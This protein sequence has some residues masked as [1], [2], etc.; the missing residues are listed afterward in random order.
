MTL[1]IPLSPN[2]TWNDNELRYALRSWE[3]YS[4]PSEVVIIG[5]K[6]PDWLTGV[7]WMGWNKNYS[8]PRDIYEK[9]KLMSQ[10]YTEFI[11]ANDDHFLL[12]P[13]KD[14]PGY[15]GLIRDFRG[16][17]ETFM[18]YVSNTAKIFPAAKYFDIHEPMRMEAKY[19]NCM[20]YPMK[21]EMLLKTA[22]GATAGVNGRPATDCKIDRHIRYDE[23]DTLLQGRWCFSVG[24]QGLNNDMK[25]WLADRFPDKSKYEL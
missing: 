22:Y 3:K 23:I 10:Y 6:V 11:F 2:S 25:R 20:Y 1:F 21:G 12:D 8:K 17:S 16:G 19:I 5:P 4:P 13:F 14:D 15:Q 24:D 18:R 9:T 7:T